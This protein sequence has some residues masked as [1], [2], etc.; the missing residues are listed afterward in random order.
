MPSDIS[1]HIIMVLSM[2][3]TNTNG[4]NFED[5]EEIKP[6]TLDAIQDAIQN[7]SA[8]EKAKLIK[9]LLGENGLQ[10]IAGPSQFNA[11][12]MFNT[13]LYQISLMDKSELGSILEAI[14]ER[15]KKN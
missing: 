2:S 4:N 5:Q 9:S 3:N 10:I 15:L 7:L 13:N 12:N 14:A 1:L 11:T 6:E 8:D